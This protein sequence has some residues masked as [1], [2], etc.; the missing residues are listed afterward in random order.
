[1][2]NYVIYGLEDY[3]ID[4]NINDIKN[5]LEI[6]PEEIIK[7]NLDEE[8]VSNAIIEASTISMFENKKFII[9]EGCKFLTGDNK[10]EINHDIDSLIKYLNNPF[11]DVVII[12]VVRNEKLDERKKIVKEIKNLCKVIEC[13]KIESYNLNNY[14]GNY[15]KEK[16]YKISNDNINLIIKKV[17]SDLSLLINEVDKLL[18]Y[19]DNNMH[20]EK[21]DIDNLICNSLEDNVFSLTNAIM[22]K[23]K[24]EIFNVYNDLVKVGNDPS[25]LL[26]ILANQYRLLLSVKL[27]KDLGYTDN[28]MV[29]TIKEHPY[30]IKLAKESFYS[31][32]SLINIIKKLSDLDYKIK[33]GKI[34]RF[35]GFE[36][37]LLNV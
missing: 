24:E 13:K 17:G 12:F 8:N 18:L 9:C 29:N 36:I 35:L 22:N 27:M 26:V 16:G 1:M 20:I 5:E 33:S 37:F 3:L 19:K 10:K 25:M 31:K 4:K 30:R 11:D 23:D 6:I 21:E 14:I 28:E 15:I 7:Y 32:K 34:D 2:N